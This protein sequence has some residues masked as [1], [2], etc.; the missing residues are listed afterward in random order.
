[1][2]PAAHMTDMATTTQNR[3]PPGVR[4]GGQFA[5]KIH[6]EPAPLDFVTDEDA[7]MLLDQA[8]KSARFGTA[9]H[10][11]G[12]HEDAEDAAMESVLTYLAAAANRGGHSTNPRGYVHAGARSHAARLLD[13]RTPRET[14]ATAKWRRAVAAKQTELGRRITVAEEDAIAEEVRLSLDAKNRPRA[15]YHRFAREASL[16]AHMEAYGDHGVPSTSH[17]SDPDFADGSLG[18]R[19]LSGGD[20]A[21]TKKALLYP[22]LAQYRNAPMPASE[23]I[24]SKSATALRKRIVDSGGALAAARAWESGDS[25]GVLLFAPF[26]DLD[27]RQQQDVV[28]VF[29]SR[30]QYADDLWGS[31]LTIATRR[32]A[33]AA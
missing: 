25:D 24:D 8:K 18:D 4:T 2:N 29:T 20:N 3:I 27:A 10:S 15:G 23:T 19:I 11:G 6:A 26:G 9:L 30:P 7:A 21:R 28:D 12:R 14:A 5:S 33:S 22:A 16:N 32:R 1:M 17:E 31:A 13:G